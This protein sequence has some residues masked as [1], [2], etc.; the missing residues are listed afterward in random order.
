MAPSSQLSL[1]PLLRSFHSL[2]VVTS[3]MRRPCLVMMSLSRHLQWCQDC[4]AA[5]RPCRAQC[6]VICWPHSLPQL[7]SS[8]IPHRLRRPPQDRLPCWNDCL[9]RSLH[10]GVRLLSPCPIFG[11][12][13]LRVTRAGAVWGVSARSTPLVMSASSLQRSSSTIPAVMT[14]CSS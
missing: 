12:T 6:C 4:P 7:P 3:P 11:L 14:W 5:D 2:L 8:H 10:D 1:R 13:L 9:R